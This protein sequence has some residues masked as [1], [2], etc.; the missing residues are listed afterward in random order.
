MCPRES[1]RASLA[2]AGRSDFSWQLRHERRLLLALYSAGTGTFVMDGSPRL[3]E[4]PV[5]PA[6][7]ALRKLGAVVSWRGR[8]GFLPVEITGRGLD[9]GMFL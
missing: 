5:G 2:P 4:R 7:E 3:R 8:D 6:V 1:A 9:R